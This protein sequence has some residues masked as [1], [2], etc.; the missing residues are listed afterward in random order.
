M[1]IIMTEVI[2]Q[3]VAKWLIFRPPIAVGGYLSSLDLMIKYI[4][5]N[6]IINSAIKTA[7]FPF[8]TG[9]VGSNRLKLPLPKVL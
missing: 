7:P 3:A 1:Y 8:Q 9:R 5:N 2:A 6:A 4:R